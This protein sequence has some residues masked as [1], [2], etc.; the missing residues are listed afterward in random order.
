MLTRQRAKGRSS[1]LGQSTAV[2]DINRSR[3]GAGSN[4]V[5]AVREKR[6]M[7]EKLASQLG[8][9]VIAQQ[10]TFLGSDGA[11]GA[12]SN[13]DMKEIRSYTEFTRHMVTWIFQSLSSN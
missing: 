12:P 13:D 6:N 4:S 3:E 2:D 10:P 11:G 9:S 7:V 8:Q 5:R 1:D